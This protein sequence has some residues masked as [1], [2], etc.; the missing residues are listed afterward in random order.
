MK[1]KRQRHEGEAAGRRIIRKPEVCR[2]TG[3]SPVQ[4][5]RLEKQ[6]LFP[7]RVQLSPMAVGWY[8]DEVDEWIRSRVRQGGKR[9]PVQWRGG[10]TTRNGDGESSKAASIS[11][12]R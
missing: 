6:G 4:L 8:E 3:Y 1:Q 7:Y 9:P 2:R 11:G 10:P 5:W 12:S